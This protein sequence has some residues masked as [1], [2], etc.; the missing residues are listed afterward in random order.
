M[1]PQKAAYIVSIGLIGK[2]DNIALNMMIIDGLLKGNS[3]TFRELANSL[4][5]KASKNKELAE[6]I[7]VLT[8]YYCELEK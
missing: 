3:T 4:I 6:A 1:N 8:N 7:S 5:Y 2:Q